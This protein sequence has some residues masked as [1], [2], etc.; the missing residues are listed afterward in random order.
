MHYDENMTIKISAFN[1]LEFIDGTS[2]KLD[3]N[4]IRGT[5]ISSYFYFLTVKKD[6]REATTAQNG[7]LQ[8]SPCYCC[9]WLTDPQ[10]VKGP[11]IYRAQRFGPRSENG[12]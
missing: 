11:F 8:T 1:C 4:T 6:I 5:F 12:W 9:T 7:T 3:T 10:H 2:K